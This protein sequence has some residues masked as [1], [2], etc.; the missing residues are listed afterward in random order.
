MRIW[1]LALLF[2]I[3]PGQRAALAQEEIPLPLPELD[4]GERVVLYSPHFDMRL[5]KSGGLTCPP[6]PL[7][8]YGFETAE[9]RERAILRVRTFVFDPGRLDQYVYPA[10]EPRV[11]VLTP[12]EAT[13]RLTHRIE[14]GEEVELPRRPPWIEVA[15]ST[16]LAMLAVRP[17]VY[18]IRLDWGWTEVNDGVVR[19]RNLRR[20]SIHAYVMPGAICESP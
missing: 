15:D 20:D 4:R 12:V 11:E 3:A 8:L 9:T 13:V 6:G 1:G 16:G 17:G 2:V 18:R 5:P 14:E 10:D 7:H 19:V